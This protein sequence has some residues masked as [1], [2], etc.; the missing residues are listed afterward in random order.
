MDATLQIFFISLGIVVFPVGFF[1]GRWL[2]QKMA[3][4]PLLSS[5]RKFI[6]SIGILG[7]VAMFLGTLACV[8]AVLVVSETTLQEYAR[9]LS[10]GGAFLLAYL[11]GYDIS[12]LKKRAPNKTDAAVTRA[13]EFKLS[14]R[15]RWD[16]VKKVFA[17][18]FLICFL[19]YLI[20]VALSF[21]GWDLFVDVLLI[22]VGGSLGYIFWEH[23]KDTGM[24]TGSFLQQLLLLSLITTGVIGFIY[25]YAIYVG[26]SPGVPDAPEILFLSIAMF[27]EC[28]AWYLLSL[29]LTLRHFKTNV[30]RQN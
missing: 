25:G 14:F 26:T 17:V 12:I 9:P 27:T 13:Q 1:G 2:W 30:F 23:L 11:I 21:I 16:L 6:R 7:T 22:A 18:V 20:L 10:W 5:M 3:Q 29:P 24:L 28:M 15:I 4:S 8:G 19:P